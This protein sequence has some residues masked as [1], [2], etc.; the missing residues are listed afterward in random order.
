MTRWHLALVLAVAALPPAE[1]RDPLTAIDSC[2]RQLDRGVD[3]GYRR[4]SARCRDLARSLR[5]SEW[6]PWLPGDGSAPDSRLGA[7]GL[8]ELRTLLTRAPAASG[9]R[10]PRVRELAAVLASVTLPDQPRGGWWTRFKAWLRQALAPRPE[11]DKNGWLRRLIA[12]LGPSQAL[13]EAITWGA[14]LIVLALAGAVIV[15]EL[16]LAGVLKRRPQAWA[17]TRA[18]VGRGA[19]TLE[20][21]ERAAPGLQPRL[22]L[23]LISARLAEQERLPPARSLTVRELTRAARLPQESDRGH[24]AELAEACERLRFSDRE[25]SSSALA[26]ALARGRELLAALDSATSAAPQG[27][28]AHA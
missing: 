11:G 25:L 28:L 12:D 27:A 14:L 13:I 3:V 8:S 17:P 19:I 4:V 15:N 10:E 24:L 1:A 26:A 23:E 22:L 7:E 2:L 5:Q 6:A 18:G 21:L 20:E 9:T 16:R